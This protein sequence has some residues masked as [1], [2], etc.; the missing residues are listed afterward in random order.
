MLDFDGNERRRLIL[1]RNSL[2]I[3]MGYVITQ[4]AALLAQRLGLSTIRTVEI[5]W[6]A[7]PTLTTTVAFAG[8][9]RMKRVISDRYV[10]V[11]QFAQYLVWLVMYGVWLLTLREIRVA[12]LF[13]A[14][15]PLAFLL[16][17]TRMMQSLF[18][19]ISAMVLQ[20]A[21][22]YIA[23]HRLGQTGSFVLEAYFTLCFAP[24]GLFLCYLADRFSRQRREVR[25]AKISAEESRD[26]LAAQ[27]EKTQRANVELQRALETLKQATDELSRSEKMAALGSLVAGISHELNTPIGN[28][29]TVTSVLHEQLKTLE[30]DV[31]SGVARR[32]DVMEFFGNANTG[33]G[34]LS[35]SLETASELIRSFKHV[36]VDRTSE[37]RRCFDLAELLEELAITLRPMLRHSRFELKLDL[38]AGMQ[39]DSYPGA[40]GQIITN[41]V[42]NA[43]THGF[44]GRSA[45]VMLIRTRALGNEVELVF[46]DDGVGIPAAHHSRVFDPFFTTKFG[47]G[48]SGLGLSLVYNAVT[49]VLG[50]T[51]RL[52][53]APDAG[54]RMILVMPCVAPLP[55]AAVMSR[56][57]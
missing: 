56:S 8:V 38:A 20:V 22:S 48:G 50:G 7:I 45:G 26:A 2:A 34:V 21:V 17:D 19:T 31:A 5:V 29:V 37:K 13:F 28:C 33:F 10:M 32:S 27:V 42:S 40:L 39:M 4:L 52:E 9:T 1:Q 41:L 51:I 47:K 53:S 11:F 46:S 54:T 44:D 14:L 35:R 55:A 24:A 30:M 36:A 16:S 3:F 15:I 57:E 12:A 43:I 6:V 25:R 23:I 49:A 18:V